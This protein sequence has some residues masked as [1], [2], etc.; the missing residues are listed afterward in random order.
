MA[1][2]LGAAGLLCLGRDLKG[3]KVVGTG[4]APLTPHW[5]SLQSLSQAHVSRSATQPHVVVYLF[6]FCTL[7][8]GG[9][10]W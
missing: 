5:Q 1:T 9:R 7:Q 6:Y 4:S 10:G 8:H 2:V 3:P